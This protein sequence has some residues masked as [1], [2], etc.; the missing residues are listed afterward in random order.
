MTFW[1][2]EHT[3]RESKAHDMNPKLSSVKRSHLILC[4]QFINQCHLLLLMEH[5]SANKTHRL[6]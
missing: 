3:G 5:R 1:R 6:L 2:R 4:R